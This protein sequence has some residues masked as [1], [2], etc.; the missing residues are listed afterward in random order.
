MLVQNSILKLM[1]YGRISPT[2]F[3]LV[4]VD[5]RNIGKRFTRAVIAVVYHACINVAVCLVKPLENDAERLHR[6]NIFCF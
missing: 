6:I 4:R 1:E 3:R 5:S 2:N